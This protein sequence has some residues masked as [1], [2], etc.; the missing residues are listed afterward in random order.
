MGYKTEA[1]LKGELTTDKLNRM[2]LWRR[3]LIP[4]YL[5]DWR[6]RE[7]FCEYRKLM[8]TNALDNWIRPG[9]GHLFYD[10]AAVRKSAEKIRATGD[11]TIYY[12]H[13]NPTR[14]GNF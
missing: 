8:K 3:L 7:S 12:G 4:E 6:V 2:T 1:L 11:R 10:R 13:G 14:N 9:I 5:Y